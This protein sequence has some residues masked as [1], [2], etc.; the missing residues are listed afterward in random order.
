MRIEDESPQ[1]AGQTTGERLY[2]W[3]VLVDDVVQEIITLQ[4]P[5]KLYIYGFY[6]VVGISF[7]S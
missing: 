4:K 1:H 6:I 3:L 7:V 5:S 2:W